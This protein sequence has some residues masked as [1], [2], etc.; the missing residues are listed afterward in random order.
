MLSVNLGKRIRSYEIPITCK[1]SRE[2]I[3]MTIFLVKIAD[4][5]ADYVTHLGL[6][7]QLSV[8]NKITFEKW[9]WVLF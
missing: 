9:A 8:Y 2:E 1:T 5:V 7:L 3:R 4:R 6:V